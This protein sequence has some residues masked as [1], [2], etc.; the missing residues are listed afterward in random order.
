MDRK[1]DK[2]LDPTLKG[3]VPSGLLA[4]LCKLGGRAE[5]GP[6][7]RSPSA[8]FPRMASG[9]HSKQMLDKALKSMG[10]KGCQLTASLGFH[11][12]ISTWATYW[13]DK[14]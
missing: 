12:S 1:C 6:C 3:N 14:P 10:K 11:V 13:E 8:P 5:V 7:T 2:L 4:G 9:L